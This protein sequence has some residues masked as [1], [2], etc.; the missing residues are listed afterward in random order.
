MR[1]L[2]RVQIGGLLHQAQAFDGRRR[3]DNPA[4]AK[5]REGYLGETIDVDN[6]IGAIQLLERRHAVFPQVQPS[7]NM[8]FHNGNLMPRRKLQNFSPRRQ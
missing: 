7:I 3:R 5:T 6:Q 8:V 2:V 4:N 1:Q